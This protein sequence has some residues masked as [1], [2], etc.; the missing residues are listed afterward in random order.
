M[1]V[2]GSQAIYVVGSEEWNGLQQALLGLELWARR[3]REKGGVGRDPG[4][5][6]Q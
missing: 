3:P 2:P 5:L 6:A 4:K 1:S